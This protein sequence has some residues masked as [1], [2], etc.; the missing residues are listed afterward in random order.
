MTASQQ[1]YF[2]KRKYLIHK[3][4]IF[5]S[6]LQKNALHILPEASIVCIL[7]G[8]IYLAAVVVKYL[9]MLF[10][11]KNYSSGCKGHQIL[12]AGCLSKSQDGAEGKI[13]K[14]TW[15]FSNKIDSYALDQICCSTSHSL[16]ELDSQTWTMHVY[17]N[18]CYFPQQLSLPK[19]RTP[20]HRDGGW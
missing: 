12:M 5:Q 1:T 20:G 11:P 9:F 3:S 16:N 7:T 8:E 13:E 6:F 4:L 15:L 19:G 2:R 14:L 17:K 18:L 10:P